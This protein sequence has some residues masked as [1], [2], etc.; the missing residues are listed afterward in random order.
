MPVAEDKTTLSGREKVVHLSAHAREALALSAQETGIVLG[1]L[2][3]NDAGAP[4]PSNG[5][6]WSLAHKSDYVTA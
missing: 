4:L 6:Y 2:E 3:K 1:A 5:Y